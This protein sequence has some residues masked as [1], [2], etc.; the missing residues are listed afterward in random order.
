MVAAQSKSVA[1][2]FSM[3]FSGALAV[4]A[5][6]VGR[7]TGASVIVALALLMMAGALHQALMLAKAR[8]SCGGGDLYFWCFAAGSIIYA[9]SAGAALYHAALSVALTPLIEYSTAIY[10]LLGFSALCFAGA[11]Y[12]GIDAVRDPKRELSLLDRLQTSGEPVLVTT[13]VE[14]VAGFC[15]VGVALLGVFGADRLGFV[16]ADAAASVALALIMVAVAAV[17]LLTLRAL[18]GG[19]VVS[20]DI[21][22]A[23]TRTLALEVER[24]GAIRR[25]DDVSVRQVGRGQMQVAVRLAF[26]DGVDAA[27]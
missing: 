23:V 4:A 5:F 7:V 25:L 6:I 22:R 1:V 15:G 10:A 3:L 8:D 26:K 11:A 16:N 13:A 17:Q 21:V 14:I 19:H 2:L 24:S 27:H 12:V 18:M 9:A 20:R